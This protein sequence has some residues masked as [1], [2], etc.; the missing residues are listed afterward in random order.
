MPT[1]N[2]RSWGIDVI[3]EIN[4]IIQTQHRPIRRAGGERTIT[5]ATGRL[6]PDVLLF[7]DQA[8]A[9]IIQGWELKMPDTP[10]TDST[11][12]LK[13]SVR[14]ISLSKPAAKYHTATSQ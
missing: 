8:Q 12:L 5:A 7:S 4:R 2:E 11:L 10:I 6:F 13:L 1:Y 14:T 3:S 9:R